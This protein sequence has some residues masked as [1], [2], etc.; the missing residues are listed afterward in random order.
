MEPQGQAGGFMNMD[1]MILIPLS[2]YQRKIEGG[3]RIRTIYVSVR[4]ISLMDRVQAQ[5]EDIIRKIIRLL[6]Q[7]MTTSMSKINSLL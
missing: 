6:I 2:T 4:D 5:I 3:D 7:I 1:E